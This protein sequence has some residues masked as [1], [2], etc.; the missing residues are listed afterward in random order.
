ML[1]DQSHDFGR[2][3]GNC[4]PQTY[5]LEIERIAV[6]SGNGHAPL[7]T[8]PI[9]KIIHGPQGIA[10][11]PRSMSFPSEMDEVPGRETQKANDRVWQKCSSELSKTITFKHFFV[12]APQAML[13]QPTPDK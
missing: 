1:G 6:A 5:L 13:V 11:G 2:S 9:K 8:T 12:P 3:V 10:P 4:I 7:G